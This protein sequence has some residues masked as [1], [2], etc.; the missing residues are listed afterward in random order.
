MFD[1]IQHVLYFSFKS[2]GVSEPAEGNEVSNDEI[3][4]CT[5]SNNAISIAVNIWKADDWPLLHDLEIKKYR[6]NFWN[7]LYLK[8][9]KSVESHAWHY[10]KR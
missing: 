4:N 7:I 2:L 9:P 6:Q 1:S 8:C 5:I 10:V 3:S